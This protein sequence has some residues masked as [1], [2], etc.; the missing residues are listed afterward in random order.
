MKTT[1]D[2]NQRI[3]LVTGDYNESFLCN[4]KELEKCCNEIQDKGS[5][6]IQHKWNNRFVRCSKKSIRDML[7]SL[8]LNDKFITW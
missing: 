1:I 5:I 2:N 4:I 7:K 8:K 3:F 6:K